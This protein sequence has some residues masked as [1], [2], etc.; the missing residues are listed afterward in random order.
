VEYKSM[1][2][3]LAGS[4]LAMLTANVIGIAVGIVMR[5]HIPEKAIK[6]FSAAVFILFGLA[7]L[8]KA[9]AK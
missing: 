3:V 6:W 7:G 1:L 2:G 4:T 8:Y 9:L 5:K